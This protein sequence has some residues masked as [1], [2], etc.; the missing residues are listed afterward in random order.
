[1]EQN[2]NGTMRFSKGCQQTVAKVP[3]IEGENE[4]T[5]LPLRQQ[6]IQLETVDGVQLELLQPS[7]RGFG[8]QTLRRAVLLQIVLQQDVLNPV[9]RSRPLPAQL[10]PQRRHLPSLGIGRRRRLDPPQLMH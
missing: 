10:L 3:K 4:K 8:L 5:Q 7:P 2:N 1:M 9:Q 6:A